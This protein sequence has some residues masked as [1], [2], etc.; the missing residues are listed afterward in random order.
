LARRVECSDCAAKEEVSRKQ[1]EREK[2]KTNLK[3]HSDR[4]HAATRGMGT[5]VGHVGARSQQHG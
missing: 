2:K 4:V 1:N 3:R 5:Q